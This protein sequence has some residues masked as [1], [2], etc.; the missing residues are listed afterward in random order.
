[1]FYDCEICFQGCSVEPIVRLNSHLVN[2]FRAGKEYKSTKNNYYLRS[3]YIMK[4]IAM[5]NGSTSMALVS[6]LFNE[7]KD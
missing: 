7:P 2:D 1:M 3:I 4:L 5:T 6:M